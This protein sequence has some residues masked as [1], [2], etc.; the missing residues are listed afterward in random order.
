[1][2]VATFD[3]RFVSVCF[4]IWHFRAFSDETK[5]KMGVGECVK[6]MIVEPFPVLFEKEGEYQVFPFSIICLLF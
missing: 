3:V 1:M 5:A 6:H 2:Q 4:F